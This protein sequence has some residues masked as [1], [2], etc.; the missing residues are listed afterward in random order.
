MLH[1]RRTLA[2]MAVAALAFAPSARA[3]TINFA[4]YTTG[5]FYTNGPCASSDQGLSFTGAN[6]FA[7]TSVNGAPTSVNLGTFSLGGSGLSPDFYL[8]DNF[9]LNVIFT[10][11]TLTSGNDVYQ[12]SILGVV[13]PWIGGGLGIHFTTPPQVFTFNGPTSSGSFSLALSDVVL[14]T[15]AISSITDI[16]SSAKLE[17]YISTTTTPEPATIGLLALG[18]VA[19]IPAARWRKRTQLTA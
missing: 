14:A 19:L 6:P 10:L 17:G 12:A 11:P 1:H 4:G 16:P 2:L 13:G 5:C 8:G 9:F 3:Q 7:A 18:L 15:G